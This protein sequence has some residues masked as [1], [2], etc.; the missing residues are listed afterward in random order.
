MVE[1]IKCIEK[2][3]ILKKNFV[4]LNNH[5]FLFSNAKTNYGNNHT[6]DEQNP[7]GEN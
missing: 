4:H 5:D 7:R 6:N 1:K 3:L 2:K